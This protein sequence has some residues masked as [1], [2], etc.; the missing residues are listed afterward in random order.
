MEAG[1]LVKIC[2]QLN[3]FDINI[4]NTVV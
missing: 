1:S 2:F 4:G 3:R